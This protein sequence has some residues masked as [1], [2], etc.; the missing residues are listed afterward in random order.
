MGTAT[1]YATP[2]SLV[3]ANVRTLRTSALSV[4]QLSSP[5]ATAYAPGTSGVTFAKV[6]LDAS[7]SSEDLKVSQ[8]LAI[9]T[10]VT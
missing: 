1:P 8:F 9:D 2:N 3:S 6:M 5:A 7:N 4:V 10:P